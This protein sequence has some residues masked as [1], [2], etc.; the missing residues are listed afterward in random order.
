M[1]KVTAKGAQQH[2]RQILRIGGRNRAYSRAGFPSE[3]RDAGSLLTERKC[4]PSRLPLVSARRGD[5][6][7]G[8]CGLGVPLWP[9]SAS[10][11]GWPPFSPPMWRVIA[12]LWVATRKVLQRALKALRRELADPKIKGSG[13]PGLSPSRSRI[14]RGR[15]GSTACDDRSENWEADR[16]TGGALKYAT[17][18]AFATGASLSSSGQ[19]GNNRL[20]R[21]RNLGQILYWPL[22]E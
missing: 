1:P 18:S 6:L 16:P 22:K 21:R 9:Q 15:C 2:T 19:F 7:F 4:Q 13:G 11:A 14:S 12:G 10:N 17:I 3:G 20:F 8:P 5:I